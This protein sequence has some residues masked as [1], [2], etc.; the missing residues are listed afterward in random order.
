MANGTPVGNRNLWIGIGIAA[1]AI[2][3]V[4]LLLVL[5]GGGD[6]DTAATTTTTTVSQ[7]TTTTVAPSTTTTTAAGTTTTIE[8]P[9]SGTG[10]PETPVVAVLEAYNE[11]GTELFSPGTVE[12]HWYQWDGLYVVLYRGI[13]ADAVSPLC[14]GNSIEVTEGEFLH[15]SNSPIG[16]TADEICV[17]VPR[18]AQGESGASACGALLYYITEI[19]IE[20]DGTLYGTIEV[21]DGSGFAGQTSRAA[22]DIASTPEFVPFQVAYTL[23]PSGVDDG[24]TVLCGS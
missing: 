2:V 18:L 10:V 20:A 13:D 15:V 8:P 6:D 11:P 21:N 16:A 9:P 19:P 7:T 24:G 1:A 5:L 4:I 14:P 17:G 22:T 3:A 12:A 23:A